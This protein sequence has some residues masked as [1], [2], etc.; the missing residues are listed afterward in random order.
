MPTIKLEL[1]KSKK[2]ADK[3]HPVCI[4]VT[5]GKMVRKSI[6]SATEDEWDAKNGR[7]KPRSQKDYQKTNQKI[8]DEFNKYEAVFLKLKN[9][10]R[11]WEPQDVFEPQKFHSPLFLAN[12]L[13]Y[14]EYLKGR[15]N[16]SYETPLAI[17]NKIN[18]YVGGKDFEIEDISKK[19]LNGFENFLSGADYKNG[20]NTIAYAIKYIKRVVNYAG[21]TNAVLKQTKLSYTETLKPKLTAEEITAIENLDLTP[22]TFIYHAKNTFLLQFYLWG[23]RIGDLL[24][25]KQTDVKDGRFSYVA[26]KTGKIKEIELNPK[27]VKILSEYL[28]PEKLYLLP[29]IRIQHNPDKSDFENVVLMNTEIKNRTMIINKHLKEIAKKAKISKNVTTHIARHTF[30]ARGDQM[31]GGNLE[32]LQQMLGHSSRAMT[33]RYINDLRKSDVLDAAARKIFE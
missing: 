21:A 22:D 27:A 14:I 26:S 5:H 23:I 16:F 24:K 12:S 20:A 10:G 29:W 6:A 11:E 4:R 18:A 30:A 2:L 31:L 15:L 32:L 28:N 33:E 1:F 3:R 8:Q 19:W 13:Q 9:S 25:A 7:I 17:H